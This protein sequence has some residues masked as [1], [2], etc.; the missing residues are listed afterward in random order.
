MKILARL[1]LLVVLACSFTACLLKEPVFTDGFAKTDDTIAGV[2]AQGDGGDPQKPE[3]AL[4]VPLDE[5]HY[6]LHYPTTEKGGIYFE[7]RPLVIRERT[8]LQLRALATLSDGI[9]KADTERYTLVWIE[10][11]ADANKLRV[12]ALT[13][14]SVKGKTPAEI[15]QAL[16][17][18]SGDWSKFFGEPAVFQRVKDR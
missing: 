13:N 3:L 17:A 6:V 14:A 16:E 5:T 8:V 1:V 2:W 4:I 9:P 11:E 15:R 7:A 18:P 10:K 12:R